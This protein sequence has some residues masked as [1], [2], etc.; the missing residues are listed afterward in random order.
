MTTSSLVRLILAITFAGALAMTLLQHVFYA[1]GRR[2]REFFAFL[3]TSG[4]LVLTLASGVA[5]FRLAPWLLSVST[6]VVGVL[7]ILVGA[8]LRAPDHA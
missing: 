8:L 3:E 6:A 2:P 1:T 7:F 5:L 4:W